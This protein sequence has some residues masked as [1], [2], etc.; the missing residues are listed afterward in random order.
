MATSTGTPAKIHLKGRG[1][2]D[3]NTQAAGV[4]RPGHLLQLNVDG[5][6]VP[7]TIAFGQAERMFALE[8]S[9]QGRPI[10]TDYASGERVTLVLALPGDEIYGWLA[11]G[12]V[13]V[14]GDFLASDGA[15]HFQVSTES[16]G[17][18][19]QDS[20]AVALEALDNSESDDINAR[21]KVR[22]L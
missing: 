5:D 10:S 9:L 19:T 17:G 11:F 2:I 1:R 21:L 22:V 18:A 20:V 14:V 8:D 13:C 7:H 15:G 6:V 4:V 12:Q 3:E 16:G